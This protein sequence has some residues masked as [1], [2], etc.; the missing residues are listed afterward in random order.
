[1]GMARLDPEARVAI[2]TLV[3]RGTSY[4]AIARLL[5]VTEGAVRYQVARMR[6]GQI[7]G[8]SAKLPKANCVA[9]AIDFWRE[10]EGAGPINVAA[11]HDWLVQEHGYDGSLRS[12]QRF[13]AA[14]WP[15]C[16]RLA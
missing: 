10:S 11:L 5:D 6:R 12:V 16:P 7:D 8:R 13:W 1:M 9:A 3:S 2:R 14:A 4:S 15:A